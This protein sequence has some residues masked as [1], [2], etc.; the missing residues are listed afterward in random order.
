VKNLDGRI[1]KLE[2]VAPEPPGPLAHLS[3]EELVQRAR[4]SR[5]RLVAQLGE[6]GVRA[7]E[8]SWRAP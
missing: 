7:A 6:D 2:D 5:A 4:A 8:A 1:A 3:D